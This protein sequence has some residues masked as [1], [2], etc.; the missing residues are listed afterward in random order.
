MP[1]GVRNDQLHRLVREADLQ[2]DPDVQ[3]LLAVHGATS[4]DHF[5]RQIEKA[6]ALKAADRTA[7]PFTGNPVSGHIRLG[8]APGTGDIHVPLLALNRHMLVIGQTGA[9]K[10][11]L[12]YNILD[13]LPV[14]FWAF[15]LKQDY[16]HLIHRRDELLVLPWEKFRFNPLQPP[17]GVSPWRWAQV[18]TDM[19]GHA[20][21][22]LS[23]SKNYLM[24][25]IVDLY[26]VY[27]VLNNEDPEGYPSLH[28]LQLFVEEDSQH[29]ASPKGQYRSRVLNRLEAMNLT[30][31]A[32]FDCSTGY[33]L[34]ELLERD[35]VFE[36]DGL[37]TD[38]Q[39]MVM[40]TLFAAVYEYR[41]AQGQRGT[42]LRHVFLLDEGK[43]V[44]S[45]YK[46]RSDDA[47]LPEID[48]LTA[49]MREFGEGLIVADQ[50][51][52][53]LTESIKANTYV[54]VLM[55]VGDRV[56][57][58][59]MAGS[60]GLTDRQRDI[61]ERLDTGEA[62]VQIGNDEPVVAQLDDYDL[63]KDITDD[64][65]LQ[66]MSPEWRQLEF[67]SRLSLSS[68]EHG[69][70]GEPGESLEKDRGS[71]GTDASQ[72]ELSEEADHL[73]QDIV[74]HPFEPVTDRYERLFTS[75]SKGHRAKKEL[76]EEGFVEEA[77]V[78][79]GGNR[80][81]LLEVTEDGREYLSSNGVEFQRK[82]R[83]GIVHRYWQ[84]KIKKQAVD[85]G[86]PAVIE[87]DDA[88]VAADVGDH[89]VAVEVAME[90]REREAD[91]VEDRLDAGYDTVV[92]ACR[93]EIV[94]S[95]IGER[96][97]DRGLLESDV[98]VRRVQTVKDWDFSEF[99]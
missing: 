82:G 78:D 48:A 99:R 88:D 1:D 59:D 7:Q 32:M 46:E 98:R 43:Q 37:G 42:G 9:G 75:R 36:F 3:K 73:F 84:N 97:A 51:A 81:K 38:V 65:L 77:E 34:N 19:F 54:S 95:G 21:S 92:V 83:G 14:P 39:N 85:Q 52:T 28:D 66:V 22:L 23:G 35:V 70:P 49:R 76:V 79:R 45:V 90:N 89:R 29:P 64:E 40:E 93:N 80:M 12:F 86:F 18:F 60:I 20:H 4:N 31:G 55:G 91:H 2:D 26:R 68:F 53:K 27:G 8:A 57:F 67:Q 17:D 94:A 41:R 33:P 6:I 69:E 11:T 30:A 10:T 74:D 5:R 47:G 50:E 61:A 96:L 63:R 15:D 71:G 87:L 25:K 16:R 62:V 13:Q 56:Q 58:D 44:F 24:A 72:I